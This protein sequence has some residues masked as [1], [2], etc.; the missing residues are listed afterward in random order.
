MPIV[1][2]TAGP[3][4]GYAAL[5]NL[6][7]QNEAAQIRAQ[8]M[9][10]A[11]GGGGGTDNPLDMQRAIQFRDE[12][13][14]RQGQQ[15]DSMVPS[16][17]DAF[18]ANARLAE[19]GQHARL[20]AE[21]SQVQLSQQETMRLQR[22]RNAIGEISSDPTLTDEEK[23]ELIGKTKYGMGPLEE[24]LNRQML[25]A[26]TQ[27]QQAMVEQYQA[28]A[29]LELQRAKGLAKSAED[30][31]QWW[32]DPPTLG[33]IAED[34]RKN[35]GI[36]HLLSEEQVMQWAKEIAV[37]QG[38]GQAMTTDER[39]NLIPLGG[40]TKGGKAGGSAG[41]G[42][43]F[44]HESGLTSEK[45]IKLERDIEKDIDRRRQE[46]VKDPQGVK[47]PRPRYPELQDDEG[48][49]KAVEK[50][51]EE[52]GMPKNLAEFLGQ[53]KSA[54]KSYQSPFASQQPETAST[55][56][57]QGQ[58]ATFTEEQ[59]RNV[60]GELGLR[61]DETNQSIQKS[62]L[63][64]Q[65]KELA[66]QLIAS[67]RAIAQRYPDP[68][69][70]PPEVAA[71]LKTMRE[72]FERIRLKLASAESA[73]KGLPMPGRGPTPAQRLFGKGGVADWVDVNIGSG[74]LGPR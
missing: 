20:Q 43:E 37:K 71:S 17:R 21:L 12:M 55:P 72:Q 34:I 15:A 36:G 56:Q 40:G 32:T 30:R 45:Y 46:T 3:V 26:K 11:G 65:D 59:A 14:F 39:G 28:H 52:A 44:T 57:G 13:M 7:G 51:L 22:M 67:G 23:A 27:Q 24:R 8:Q 47:E 31:I 53:R 64:Q 50:R 74:S 49:R 61:L 58:G 68:A 38:V 62:G 73:A 42:E 6:Q 48:F 5:G 19:Q 16:A 33:A 41:Q 25:L 66:S 18:L 4:G 70:R 10:R 63:S 69:T 54:K 35:S 60:G 2:E 1:Y 29:A 9:A